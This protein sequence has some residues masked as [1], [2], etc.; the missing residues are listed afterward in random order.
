M[1][2]NLYFKNPES[3][4]CGKQRAFVDFQL[5]K[6]LWF[7][8]GTKCNLSCKNCYIES[9]PS[10]DRLS[11]IET[12]DITPF[13]DEIKENQMTTN[14]IGLTGGEPFLNPQII[15]ILEEILSRGFEVLV[16][17]NA[18]RVLERHKIA[19][20]SLLVRYSDKLHIRISLDHHTKELHEKERGQGTFDSCLKMVEWLFVSRF[21]ISIAGRS[22]KE[23]TSTDAKCSYQRLLNSHGISIDIEKKLVIF[24][25]MDLQKNVPE[26]STGCWSILGKRPEDQM[27][28]TQRMVIKKKGESRIVVMPCTLLAYDPKFEMGYSLK[29]S[30][31][32]V[33][34]AH[35]F[36]AQFCV[37]GGASC[38]STK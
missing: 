38:S 25:E 13:L 34:L 23:E 16:L 27:C 4:V 6:T 26:I 36:C 2:T 3:T 8:T 24:P 33:H 35:K 12:K 17:T 14:L 1:D 28:A 5:L 9:S 32:R 10:N 21:N 19:L 30:L 11:F 18:H 15:E 22:L 37:L 7:N 29:E 31:S 20:L